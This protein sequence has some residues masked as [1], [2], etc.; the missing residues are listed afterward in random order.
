MQK[1]IALDVDQELTVDIALAVGAAT[2]TVTV[3]DAPPTVNTSDAVL[4]GPSSPTRSSACPWSTA[5]S[6]PRFRS[7][8][9]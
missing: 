7:R 5:T 3:T 9:V 4:G 6:T 2:Q 1:N 8:P